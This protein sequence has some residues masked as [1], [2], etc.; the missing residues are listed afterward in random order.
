MDTLEERRL[1][2]VAEDETLSA[3]L[4]RLLDENTA[5]NMGDTWTRSWDNMFQA[6]SQEITLRLAEIRAALLTFG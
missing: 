3:E 6:R 2:L 4:D 5:R 1:T